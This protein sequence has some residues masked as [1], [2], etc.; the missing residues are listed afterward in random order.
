MI[1]EDKKHFT[2]GMLLTLSFFA[3]LFYMFTPSFG[4]KNAFDASDDLFNSISKGSLSEYIPSLQKQALAWNGK[5]IDVAIKVKNPEY[6][7]QLESLLG[8]AGASMGDA[9]ERIKVQGDLGRLLS[10]T[11]VDAEALFYNRGED[12]QARYNMD[13]KLAMY[14]W[15]QFYKGLENGLKGQKKFKEAAF[16]SEV[17]KRGVELSYNYYGVS[18]QH[19]GDKAGILSFSLVFYVIYTMWW[20]FAIF[21]LFEGFGLKMTKGKKKEM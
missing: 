1:I 19:A 12:L 3:V 13:P 17:V 11:L 20:G 10:A 15:S 18:P 7:P 8:N 4:G 6:A 21:F 14:V 16:V 2:W 9:G 5:Q